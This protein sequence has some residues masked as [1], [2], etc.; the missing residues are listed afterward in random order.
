[1][2]SYLIIIYLEIIWINLYYV[3]F[4]LKDSQ[5][6]YARRKQGFEPPLNTW[7]KGPLK[8]WAYQIISE[9]DDIIN[10]KTLKYF[11]NDLLKGKK[12]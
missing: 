9:N 4:C 10:T 3:I 5:K 12:N 8:D 2:E 1:M 6:I 11:F 7:L